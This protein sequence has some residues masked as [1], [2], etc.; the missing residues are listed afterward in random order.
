MRED[1]IGD[2]LVVALC[3]L[4]SGGRAIPLGCMLDVPP[5]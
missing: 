5:R 3:G 2:I 4:L 1:L